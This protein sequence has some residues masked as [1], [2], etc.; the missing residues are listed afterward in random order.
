MSL[1]TNGSNFL[2][3]EVDL[4]IGSFKTNASRVSFDLIKKSFSEEVTKEIIDYSPV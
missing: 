1:G 4:S 2:V 3:I